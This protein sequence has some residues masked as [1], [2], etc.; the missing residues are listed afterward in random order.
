MRFIPFYE[1]YLHSVVLPKLVEVVTVKQPCSLADFRRA[2][3]AYYGLNVSYDQ[4][5][6]WVR[7]LGITVQ[8]S[9]A[10]RLPQRVQQ[11]PGATVSPDP[12]E[13][14]APPNVE[15]NV[16]QHPAPPAPPPQEPPR[17]P[18]RGGIA[19]PDLFR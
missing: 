16:G 7:D 9:A 1:D 12:S 19:L 17:M 10:I 4:F 11:T 6:S 8:K 14:S 13:A 2:F 15:Y 5:R 3:N 18:T